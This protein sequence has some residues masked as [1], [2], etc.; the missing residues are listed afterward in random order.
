VDTVV[1]WMRVL[2][3]CG[4]SCRNS[5]RPGASVLFAANEIVVI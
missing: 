1:M 5:L 3:K 4:S 2:V